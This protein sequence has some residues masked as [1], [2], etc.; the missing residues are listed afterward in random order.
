MNWLLNNLELILGNIIFLLWLIF[1]VS[2]V[3]QIQEFNNELSYKVIK[4]LCLASTIDKMK[5]CKEEVIL[6]PRKMKTFVIDSY[7]FSF[8]TK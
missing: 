8:F 1:D 7:H 6:K 5:S 2:F 4:K 3:I